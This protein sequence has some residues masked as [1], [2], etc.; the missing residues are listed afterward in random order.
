MESDSK[1]SKID[2]TLEKIE[3]RSRFA[4]KFPPYEFAN[5]EI[6]GGIII[7]GAIDGP[8]VQVIEK[9]ATKL[10]LS[11]RDEDGEVCLLKLQ[12]AVNAITMRGY[13]KQH[14]RVSKMPKKYTEMD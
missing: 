7:T 5:I 13:R 10:K 1:E 9:A 8:T 12:E 11:I 14:D 3:L 6:E 2:L 4:A